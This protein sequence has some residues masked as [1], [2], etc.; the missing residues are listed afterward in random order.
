[1]RTVKFF[2]VLMMLSLLGAQ[3]NAQGNS[4]NNNGNVNVAQVEVIEYAPNQAY[5]TL[6]LVGQLAP[7]VTEVIYTIKGDRII[8]GEQQILLDQSRYL[9]PDPEWQ[10]DFNIL[11]KTTNGNGNAH[12]ENMVEIEISVSGP[13]YMKPKVKIAR[14]F[15]EPIY[16]PSKGF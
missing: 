5:I 9:D 14:R 15:R 16:G 7:D 12:Q 11:P 8:G 6:K 13:G 2:L 10:V 3:V 4:Q 1:M